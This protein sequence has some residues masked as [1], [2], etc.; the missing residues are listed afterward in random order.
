M[1]K[2]KDDI[3]LSKLANK[4]QQNELEFYLSEDG[5]P[6]I[7]DAENPGNGKEFCLIDVSWDYSPGWDYWV[8][9]HKF[10]IT[11]GVRHETQ[12]PA[13]DL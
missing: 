1:N 7:I 9:T 11:Y 5:I 3:I 12:V 6:Y 8:E 4:N 2:E 13:S 10:D